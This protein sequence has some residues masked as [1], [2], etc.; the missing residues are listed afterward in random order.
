MS[1]PAELLDGLLQGFLGRPLQAEIDGGA[2]DDDVVFLALHQPLDLF[3]GP[4]EK[5]VGRLAVAAL[6][7]LG[8]VHAR[9]IDLAL[10]H[11]AGFDHV[12]QHLVGARARGGKVD[13]RRVAGGG[14]EHAGEHGRLGKVHLADRFVEI[15]LCRGLHPVR[16][17][18]EIGAI[19][20]ELEDLGLGVAILQ[21][22][23]DQR[24]SDL[25]A[26]GPLRRQEHILGE[27]LGERAA[28]LHDLVVAGIGGERPEGA[29][30]IDAE[31]F[32]ETPV[33]GRER[34]LDHH[35]GDFFQRHRVVAQQPA[36]AD[37]VAE[38]IEEGDAVLV[39]EIDL[40]LRRLEGWKSEGGENEEAGDADGQTLAG[41]LIERADEALDLEA[42]EERGVAAPPVAEAAPGAIEA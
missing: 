10:A 32:E 30:D 41:K 19:E 38:A 2:G 16:T 17:A 34:R 14:L 28:A 6:D 37:L 22:D 42:V 13:V 3:E 5:I 25:S 7:D 11:E 20:I 35:V 36:L 4:V 23:R 8:G 12:A 15:V 40:A 31:M 9:A 33:L 1:R 26:Q 27:L 18:A 39:G 29:H 21:I 24:L